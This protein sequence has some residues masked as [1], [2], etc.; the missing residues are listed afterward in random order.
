M[1]QILGIIGFFLA[2]LA[3]IVALVYV[4]NHQHASPECCKDNALALSSLEDKTKGNADRILQIYK[5]I[6][7]DMNRLLKEKDKDLD[8]IKS[9]ITSLQKTQKRQQAIINRLMCPNGVCH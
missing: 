3:L 5:N 1:K 4:P 6:H 8:A 9:S 7:E 2:G